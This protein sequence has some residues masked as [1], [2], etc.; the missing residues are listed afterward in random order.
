MKEALNKTGR[1]IWYSITQLVPYNDTWDAMHC[2]PA[3]AFTVRPWVAAGLDP[4]TLANSYLIEYCNNA[5]NFGHT[6]GLW[7]IP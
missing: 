5:N 3:Q 1:P 7:T 2:V 6:A 4:T